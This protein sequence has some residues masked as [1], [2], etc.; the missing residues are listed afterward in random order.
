MRVYKA[1][2][3]TYMAVIVTKKGRDVEGSWGAMPRP[4]YRWVSFDE[5][6]TTFSTQGR[7]LT[8]NQLYDKDGKLTSEKFEN[9]PV[10][11]FR[12]ILKTGREGFRKDEWNVE[13][14]T[15]VESTERPA[16][17]DWRGDDGFL[18]LENIMR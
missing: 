17:F 5:T 13:K 9:P 10:L 15:W 16:A 4:L 2:A 11:E 18:E 6:I 14:N 1:N 12:D 3:L 7:P 8:L